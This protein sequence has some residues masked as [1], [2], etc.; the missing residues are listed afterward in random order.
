MCHMVAIQVLPR[1]QLGTTEHIGYTMTVMWLYARLPDELSI[2]IFLPI[3]QES[4]GKMQ[5]RVNFRLIPHIL[6]QEQKEIRASIASD[7]PNRSASKVRGTNVCNIFH[8]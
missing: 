1:L 7:L 6:I 2:S 3:T 8:P 5:L 4:L